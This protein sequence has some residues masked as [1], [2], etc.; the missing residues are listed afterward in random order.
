MPCAVVAIDNEE[1]DSIVFPT[2][3]GRKVPDVDA[4][5]VTPAQPN[6][7]PQ[8]GHEFH[9]ASLAPPEV[10]CLL[11]LH[12]GVLHLAHNDPHVH[13]ALWGTKDTPSSTNTK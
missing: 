12:L 6:G 4:V 8:V 10:D 7:L 13:N 11:V 3:T 9:V 1:T 2:C 5:K